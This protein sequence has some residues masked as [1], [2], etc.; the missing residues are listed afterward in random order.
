L[1]ALLITLGGAIVGSVGALNAFF[2]YRASFNSDGEILF[3]EQGLLSIEVQTLF[4]AL[5]VAFLVA[6]IVLLLL[7]SNVAERDA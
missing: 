5:G 6:G 2:G 4:S 3:E 7:R 1:G